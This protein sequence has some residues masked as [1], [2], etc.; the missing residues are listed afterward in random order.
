ML[1]STVE[2]VNSAGLSVLTLTGDRFCA[3][4]PASITMCSHVRA[5]AI[6]P[7]DSAHFEQDQQT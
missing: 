7:N 5:A 4:T 3:I 6:A 2:S 1:D